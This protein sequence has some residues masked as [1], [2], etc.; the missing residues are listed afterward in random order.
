[1]LLAFVRRLGE[2]L[3]ARCEAL[4]PKWGWATIALLATALG[5]SLCTPDYR[6]QLDVF[7][8]A[9][10]RPHPQWPD[11]ELVR[12]CLSE[13]IDNP[14]VR[15][16]FADSNVGLHAEKMTFRLSMPFLGHILGLR[17]GG[18]ILLQQL[19]GVLFLGLVWKLGWRATDDSVCAALLPF[20]FAFSYVGQA[21]FVDLIAC[22]DGMALCGLAVAMCFRNPGVI[23]LG[24]CF[25][26]WTDERAM[27][28]SPLLL[29]WWV[30]HQAG[31]R[32]W[33]NPRVWAVGLGVLCYVAGR[34]AL[35]HLWHVRQWHKD[36]FPAGTWAVRWPIF[37]VGLAFS[38]KWLWFIIG[39]AALA[40]FLSRKRWLA[41][42]MVLFVV[43][44]L[45]SC[46]L[47]WDTTRSAAY[48]FPS[49]ILALA[50]LSRTESLTTIRW[51]LFGICVLGSLT[52]SGYV[53]GDIL[54]FP[55]PTGW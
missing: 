12:H 21:C 53:A 33:R 22:F 54:W 42:T 38:L 1:M 32:V 29:M 40:A 44:Y 2:T 51:L 46:T 37:L 47:V 48:A 23:F 39:A 6:H 8:L 15:H 41:A 14:F 30:L 43:A 19:C 34:L 24:M 9:P 13:Q 50:F 55:L 35:G 3:F 27:V 16:S 4:S 45:G 5:V 18:L 28:V 10:H 17:L 7:G 20:A 25:A 11:L 31:P 26:C 52:P 36:L 49:V